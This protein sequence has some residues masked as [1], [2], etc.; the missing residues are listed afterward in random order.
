MSFVKEM[1]KHWDNRME[2]SA[3]EAP[4]NIAEPVISFVECFKKNPRRFKMK[5]DFINGGGIRYYLIDRY[6]SKRFLLSRCIRIT[7]MSVLISQMRN[8]N[9]SKSM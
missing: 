4:K 1:L 6:S 7:T 9:T 5:A 8:K 2:E 3:K